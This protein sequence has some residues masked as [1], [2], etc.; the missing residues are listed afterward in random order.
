MNFNNIADGGLI[1]YLIILIGA[2]AIG[3]FVERLLALKKEKKNA[4]KKKV[5]KN[6]ILN[7]L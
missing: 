1:G 3:V 6:Y 5:K 2:I 7:L 4:E